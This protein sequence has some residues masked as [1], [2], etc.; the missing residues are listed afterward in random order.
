MLNEEDYYIA[1]EWIEKHKGDLEKID[2]AIRIGR[3]YRGFTVATLLRV[4][5]G[6]WLDRK[7]DITTHDIAQNMSVTDDFEQ[8]TGRKKVL[9]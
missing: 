7:F 1:E 5:L 2:N 3:G 6:M 4:L 8:Y 9:K